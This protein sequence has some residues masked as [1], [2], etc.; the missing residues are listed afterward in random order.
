MRLIIKLFLFLWLAAALSASAQLRIVA[1]SSLKPVLPELAQLWQENHP[2]MEVELNLANASTLHRLL[3]EG[4]PCDI[5]LTADFPDAPAPKEMLPTTQQFF[6]RN[7][8]VVVAKPGLVADEE[9]DWYDLIE[10]EWK[11][12]AMPDPAMAACG[13]AARAA[14]Q[15][16]GVNWRKK[17][18]YLRI[19]DEPAALNCL[20]RGEAEACFV[21]RTD[22]SP[23]PPP[24]IRRFGWMQPITLPYATVPVLPQNPHSILSA[25]NF[26][27]FLLLHRPPKNLRSE[28]IFCLNLFPQGY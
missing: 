20:K 19:G 2:G 12:V 10:R 7:E 22:V 23:L 8:L 15:K 3:R 25:G 14:A 17:I 1:D 11:S 28:A 5:I 9:L 6:A 24:G 13:K 27:S 18:S 16:R 21:W 4:Q 26:L